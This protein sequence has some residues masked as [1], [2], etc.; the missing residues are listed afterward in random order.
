MRHTKSLA[1]IAG[2]SSALR[3]SRRRATSTSTSMNAAPRMY[4]DKPIPGA[5]LV[6]TG[7]QRPPEVAARTYAAQQSATNAQL[8]ASN[9]RIADA[10][11]DARVAANVAK[12]LE[13]TRAER[14]KKARDR[15]P[16]SPSTRAACIA[17]DADGKR[18]I[19]VSDAEL[20]SQRVESA[21]AGRSHLR[22]PGLSSLPMLDERR[23][24]DGVFLCG[25]CA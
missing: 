11:N 9:Q 1:V 23:P 4:T 18:D 10:Q 12:D 22:P 14:C 25:A 24:L 15:L 3:A 8:T 5:V 21:Q 19:P 13:A 20:A 17:T 7:S 6:S 2:V 16:D